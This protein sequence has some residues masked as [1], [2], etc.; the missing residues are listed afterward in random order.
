MKHKADQQQE[1]KLEP[2]PVLRTCFTMREFSESWGI[3][4]ST[5]YLW[6]T[7]GLLRTFLVGRRRFV[8]VEESTRLATQLTE[9]ASKKA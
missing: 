6:V 7:T 9:E 5:A 1:R 2:A 4:R 8:A 3:S